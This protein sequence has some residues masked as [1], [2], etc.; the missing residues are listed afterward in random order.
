M[1]VRCRPPCHRQHVA[2]ALVTFV[3][4][5]LLIGPSI[6]RAERNRLAVV[7]GDLVHDARRQ[8]SDSPAGMTLFPGSVRP[9][10]LLR[11]II[12]GASKTEPGDAPVARDHQRGDTVRAERSF[13][14]NGIR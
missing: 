13:Q 4:I 3:T 8:V 7:P 11:F 9:G 14:L 2:H 10:E 5:G 6:D 12:D 1:I